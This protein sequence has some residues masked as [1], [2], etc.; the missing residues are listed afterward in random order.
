M[1]G[2]SRKKD[3]F[4]SWTYEPDSDSRS[5]P[6]FSNMRLVKSPATTPAGRRRENPVCG[7]GLPRHAR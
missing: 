6:G 2:T 3:L 1:I 4:G 7:L 5:L